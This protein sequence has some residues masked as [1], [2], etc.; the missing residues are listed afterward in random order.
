MLK[1]SSVFIRENPWPF[2]EY[3]CVLTHQ[4]ENAVCVRLVR[5]DAPYR[6]GRLTNEK[7]PVGQSDEARCSLRFQDFR[8]SESSTQT[9]PKMVC[10]EDLRSSQASPMR[11]ATPFSPS[12]M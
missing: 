7:S 2:A 10:P 5:R 1:K 9:F 3:G 6:D 4:V 11:V 8:R 12:L